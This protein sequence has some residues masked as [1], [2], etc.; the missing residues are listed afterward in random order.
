[1]D[2]GIG[3]FGTYIETIKGESLVIKEEGVTN[4]DNAG[5]QSYLWDI[6]VMDV[7]PLVLPQKVKI[8]IEGLRVL[9]IR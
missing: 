7:Y 8:Y 6:W 4:A 1:M 9:C 5:I 2:Q 3:S